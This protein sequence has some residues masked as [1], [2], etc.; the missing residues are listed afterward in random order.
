MNKEMKDAKAWLNKCYFLSKELEADR[1][2][3]EV[4][5]SRLGANV[6]KYES[7]GTENHDPDAAKARHDD[8]LLDYSMQAQLV[9]AK[10]RELGEAIRKRQ[11]AIEELSDPAHRAVAKDRYLNRLR[12]E[13]VAKVEHISI[14]Q[15]YRVNAAML[16]RMVQVL[17]HFNFE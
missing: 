8:A 5:Q 2:T 11:K 7:D 10:E 15:V 3:L 14:A 17:R 13:D 16:E 4:M 6:S 12:W 9:E 1:R